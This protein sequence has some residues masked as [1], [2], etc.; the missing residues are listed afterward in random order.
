MKQTKENKTTKPVRK[1]TVVLIVAAALA[2]VFGIMSLLSCD[3][4]SCSSDEMS[5]QNRKAGKEAVKVLDSYLDY[6]ITRAEAILKMSDLCTRLA[7]EE[8]EDVYRTKLSTQMEL[9]VL[10][11]T[12]ERP[13]SMIL[14]VRNSI[15]ENV[16]VR[17]R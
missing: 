13:D 8:Y 15:A 9:A 6:E 5:E 11:L 1:N 3:G 10:Y 16:G 17:K 12:N 4:C 7:D 2:L 14:E